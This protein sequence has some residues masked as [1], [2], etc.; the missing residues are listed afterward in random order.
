MFSFIIEVLE[1]I[2][3]DDL[4]SKQRYEATNLLESMQSF[5]LFLQFTFDESYIGN[6]K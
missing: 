2:M 5:N 1:I 6:Y 3:E 4:N